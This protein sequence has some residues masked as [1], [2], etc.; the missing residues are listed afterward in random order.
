MSNRAATTNRAPG[1]R[2]FT[3]IEILVVV[4]I[5]A[6]LIS[7]LLPS[8]KAARDEAKKVLC[9]SNLHQIGVGLTSY[10][11]A[12][13]GEL[14][15]RY[16]TSSTFTTYFMRNGTVHNGAVG[17]GLLA[18][19]RYVPEPLAF[20][21]SG[22]DPAKSAVL[23][24]NGPDNA[25]V[26]DAAYS[27]MT[28]SER[29]AV[30]VRSSY[31]ARPIMT[32]AVAQIGAQPREVLIPS[33]TLVGWR[34]DKYYQKVL[35]TDFLGVHGF[36]NT[37][38][39]SGYIYSPHDKKGYYRLFGDTSARWTHGSGLERLR[40]IDANAPDANQMIEYWRQLDRN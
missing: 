21:C 24:H 31:M 14:P 13:K 6:L 12:H 30:K 33:G 16:R 8:L 7:I 29:G 17:L 22:Q 26:S 9:G 10:V 11:S 40:K 38:T 36:F 18:N 27:A 4:A 3:L 28:S 39:D 2:A 35:Y 32:E 15:V 19:R 37:A 1:L 34:Q 5:I 20:Y 25:W 23:S